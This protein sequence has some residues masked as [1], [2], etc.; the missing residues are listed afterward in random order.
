MVGGKAAASQ[1]MPGPFRGSHDLQRVLDEMTESG[2]ISKQKL[3]PK[4]LIIGTVR[5]QIVDTKNTLSSSERCNEDS[6]DNN[7]EERKERQGQQRN[8]RIIRSQ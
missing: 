3:P 5:S 7:E 4:P 2:P 1:A 6:A 8:V